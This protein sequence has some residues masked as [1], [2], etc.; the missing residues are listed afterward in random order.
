MMTEKGYQTETPAQLVERL[1]KHGTEQIRKA[2]ELAAAKNGLFVIMAYNYGGRPG[3]EYR[4]VIGKRE[5]GL[6]GT[7]LHVLGDLAPVFYTNEDYAQQLADTMHM[8]NGAGPLE[9]VVVT[10]PSYFQEV[11]KDKRELLATCGQLE[12]N[13]YQLKGE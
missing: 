3:I 2:E 7:P 5:T 8:S 4:Y 6:N 13:N 10:A 12:A 9:F 11:I 1:R